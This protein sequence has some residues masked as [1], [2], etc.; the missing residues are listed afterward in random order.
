[1]S[2]NYRILAP[3]VLFGFF[4][5]TVLGQ[6]FSTPIQVST[7]GGAHSPAMH[8]GRDGTIYVSWFENSADIYFSHSI[9]G[10]ASFTPPVHVSQQITT[11]NQNYQFT[12]LL[13]R[14]PN[15]AI[16]TKGVI[17]LV[18]MDS[19]LNNPETNR[20]Q[21]DIWYVRSTDKGATW[22]QPRSIMDAD[23]SEKYAQD[24]P[25]IACD[26]SDNLYVS[27]LDNR[28]LMRGLLRHYKMQCERSTDGGATWSLPVIADKLPVANSGTCECCRDD[29]AVS[30]QGHV[31]IAFRTSMT[32][33]TGDMR[34]IFI[35]RSMDGGVT[36]DRS[37]QCQLGDWNLTACPT[38]GP[39]IALD[40]NENLHVAWA[41][42]RDDSSGKLISYYSLLR[43]GDSAVFPNYSVA[44]RGL[45][46]EEWPDLAYSAG[47]TIAYAYDSS[48][49]PILFSYSSDGGNTWHRHVPF[50]GGSGDAQTIPALAFDASGNLFAAWQ[51]ASANGILFTKIS[52]LA[53]Q[54]PFA[55]TTKAV[56]QKPDNTVR[57]SWWPPFKFNPFV[58]Y[59]F[60]LT[61]PDSLAITTRDSTVTLDS[62]AAGNYD[63]RILAHTTAGSCKEDGS[64]RI[65]P[66]SVTASQAALEVAYPNPVT[67][68]ILTL[69]SN[70]MNGLQQLR[71]VD[72]RGGIVKRLSITPEGTMLKV[73]VRDLPSGAYTCEITGKTLQRIRFVIP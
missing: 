20:P 28:Y 59:D 40:G 57:L 10:G 71:I 15:F 25:A 63:Y 4:A 43:P 9:N 49:G 32:E 45:P 19:R 6:T 3:A 36:F 2:M 1:M 27:Y 16:D 14:A 73:D 55:V 23:D 51:D 47:G 66:A 21:S 17:H 64:F 7:D 29:I 69:T 50:P 58:W 60:T 31:Y 62:L 30:P 67:D 53:A 65:Y 13:Q 48:A 42:A 18:W 11:N 38:K 12:S 39:Q 35:A 5:T 70:A 52:E 41:D 61:G 37:I 24:F 46:D 8:V 54:V 44:S 34:D 56:E 68:G 33:D 72:G 22:T 26:S